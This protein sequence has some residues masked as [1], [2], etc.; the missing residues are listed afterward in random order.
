MDTIQ[1]SEHRLSDDAD[2]KFSRYVTSRTQF[3]QL[4]GSGSICTTY[5]LD[6]SKR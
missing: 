6:T 1:L 5:Y 4:N 2:V 3:Q